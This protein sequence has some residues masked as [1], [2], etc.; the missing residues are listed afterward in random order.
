MD[1]VLLDTPYFCFISLEL[2]LKTAYII[3]IAAAG[4]SQRPL[5]IP[6]RRD[7]ESLS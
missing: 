1:K 2:S 7:A 3:S 4:V 6:C 5:D